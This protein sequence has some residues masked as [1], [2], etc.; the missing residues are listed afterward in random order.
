MSP[1]RLARS[2]RNSSRDSDRTRHIACFS[3][4]GAPSRRTGGCVSRVSTTIGVADPEENDAHRTPSHRHQ[5][6]VRA[7]RRV[8]SFFVTELKKLPRRLSL[9]ALAIAA[10]TSLAA[11]STVEK[12]NDAFRV[13][14]VSFPLDDFEQLTE[15]LTSAGQLTPDTN[16]LLSGDEARSVL[17]SLIR[18][19]AAA[20][21]LTTIDDSV[22]D[23]DR[24]KALASV[25]DG[26]IDGWSD[27][28]K[29]TSLEL[30]ALQYAFERVTVPSKDAVKSWYEKQPA[31]T[32]VLCLSHILVESL[33]T[34]NKVIAELEDGGDFT[35]IAKETSTEP[36]AKE[37]G[38]KLDEGENAC[39]NLPTLQEQFDADF[40]SAAIPGR[41]TM[42]IG[43][44]RSQFGYH[45]IV[46]RPWDEVGDAVMKRLT[47]NSASL[48]AI[49]YLASADVWV[50]SQFGEWNTAKS[51]VQ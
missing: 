11:C 50:N 32:G 6:V 38:G 25:P 44:V 37:S 1:P 43:P 26:A 17:N 2:V 14:G 18:G 4:V 23:E 22:T 36:A 21:F 45:V 31:L 7:R 49:G 19:R 30:N 24:Q 12:S 20:Q 3:V 46:H 9:A 40:M 48:L 47:D 10:T 42:V 13:N 16:G 15:D 34:A 5:R 41:P 35:K 33:D 29:S 51:A 27:L 28:L 8:G 39:F